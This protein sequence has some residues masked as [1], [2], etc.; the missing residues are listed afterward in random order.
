MIRNVQGSTSTSSDASAVDS[1]DDKKRTTR[2]FPGP[3]RKPAGSFDSQKFGSKSST[4]DRCGFHSHHSRQVC[5]V[6]KSQCHKC[7]RL[8][9]WSQQCCSKTFVNKV[10]LDES[11]SSEDDIFLGEVISSEKDPW[12]AKITVN[13]C[14]MQFKLESGADVTVIP[15]KNFEEMAS[16]T[17]P[18]GNKYKLVWALS[19]QAHLQREISGHIAS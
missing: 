4:C 11:S 15:S 6:I 3:H 16:A 5:P 19:L 14:L 7:G 13:N 18:S 17:A 10:G 12:M 1:T 9:N 8:G 2:K